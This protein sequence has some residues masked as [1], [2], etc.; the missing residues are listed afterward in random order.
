VSDRRADADLDPARSR[1][2]AALGQDAERADHDR[3]G[4]T[5]CC[6][7]MASTKAPFLSGCRLPSRLARAFRKDDGR[8]ACRRSRR[9]AVS[10]E[11]TG[12]AAIVAIDG[13]LPLMRSAVPK[14]GI[15]N[16]SRLAT[17]RNDPGSATSST[18]TSTNERW[19]ATYT[20]G[21][22]PDRCS[23]PVVSTSMP[24]WPAVDAT[25]LAGRDRRFRRPPTAPA[26]HCGRRVPPSPTPV[27]PSSALRYRSARVT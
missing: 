21:P 25:I 14:T 20:Q 19:F 12:R 5:G 11:A 2:D 10:N 15:R 16:S 18:Q 6:V 17:K 26:Q 27:P 24:L 22:S 13:D 7:A 23:S 9:P 8:V 1:H 3:P 4:T